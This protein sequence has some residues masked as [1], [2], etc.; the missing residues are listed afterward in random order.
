MT[1]NAAGFI[2]VAFNNSLAPT[3]L[4]ASFV[5]GAYPTTDTDRTDLFIAQIFWD[6]SNSLIERVEQIWT[7]GDWD[8]FFLAPDG[9]SIDYNTSG[10]LQWYDFESPTPVAITS[11]D[12]IPYKDLETG[13]VQYVEAGYL[14]GLIDLD[15]KSINKNGT[16]LQMYNFAA[17]SSVAPVA[18]D[19]FAYK[20]V[21]TGFLAWSTIAAMV[22]AELDQ[23]SL[24]LNASNLAQIYGYATASSVAPVS[25]DF[26]PFKDTSESHISWVDLDDLAAA[27]GGPWWKLGGAA[28]VCYGEEIG[29]D[30]KTKVI[31]LDEQ[32][33]TNG[34]WEVDDTT[35]A[36]SGDGAL[37]VTTGGVYA[38]GG[39]YADKGGSDQ[40][41]YFADGTDT[42]VML[43][44]AIGVAKW[45]GVF[46]RVNVY[47]RL[48]GNA[49]A[50][51]FYDG[52]NTINLGDSTYAANATVGGINA[53]STSGFL[54]AGTKVVG[55]QGA[56]VADATG[57]GD[58]VAQLNALLAR[59]R[60][61]GLIAT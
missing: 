46:N 13:K 54:C 5:S 10:Q 27:M 49:A 26:I 12:Y 53:N 21:S 31:D 8:S 51:A 39:V 57:A 56:A 20:D 14:L 23:V 9:D 35:V 61:H 40:A 58:V 59:L 29:N 42:D 45:A 17:A 34:S 36:A 48:G 44:G 38:G 41:G 4:T 25:G 16:E 2:K 50:G 33:L 60:A 11:D 30:A 24:N 1:C 15:E 22:G 18:A 19:L 37:E 47:A 3:T 6:T 28:S 7:G 52:V 43:C 55:A 32:T